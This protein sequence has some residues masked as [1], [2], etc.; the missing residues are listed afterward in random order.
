MISVGS[1]YV[2]YKKI[3][4]ILK[5]LKLKEVRNYF[6]FISHWVKTEMFDLIFG[7]STLESIESNW[8]ALS[9]MTS[10]DFD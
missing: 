7:E 3:A 10:Y 2:Y 5:C 1:R 9:D 4:K 6:R 8:T